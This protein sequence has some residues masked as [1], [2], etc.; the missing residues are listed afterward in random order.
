[1]DRDMEILMIE[2]SFEDVELAKEALLEAKVNSNLHHVEDG[3]YGIEFLRKKS[4]YKNAPTPDVILLDINMPRKNGIEVLKE[5]KSDEFL[6]IIPIIVL[7]TSKA[8]EDILKSY[9]LHANCYITK[10]LD[11]DNFIKIVKHIEAF[12]FSIV[13]LP[14]RSNE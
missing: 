2:D 5:V 9:K 3:V 12:W 10:P 11:F 8:E 13:R 7:T 1:M 6:K 14:T 4:K